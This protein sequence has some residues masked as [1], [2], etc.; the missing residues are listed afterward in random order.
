MKKCYL[1]MAALMLG[2]VQVH[3]VSAE[4]TGM[5]ETNVQKEEA[6]IDGA[7][8]PDATRSESLAKQFNVTPEKVQELRSSGKGWGG[9]T[10]ELAMAE[11]LMK[12]DPTN[13][14]TMNDAIA[15]VDAMRAEGQ[16]WGQI[17]KSLGF[18]L[19]P[20]VS[21]ARH[22][23]HETQMQMKSERMPRAERP[24]KA[25]KAERAPKAPR[26]EKPAKAH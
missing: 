6:T 23:R 13:Y 4:E 7:S 3:R 11:Q 21:A 26:P 9:V 19:G 1:V 2:S 15:K 10:I 22:A 16:G 12:Q 18:K 8:T 25:M 24:E 14:P 20:V 5:D 17:S